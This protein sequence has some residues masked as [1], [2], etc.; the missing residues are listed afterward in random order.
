MRGAARSLSRLLAAVLSMVALGGCAV[1]TRFAGPGYAAGEGVTAPGSGP[2]LVVITEAVQQR[3]IGRRA[4]FLQRVRAVEAALAGRRGLVGYALRTELLGR[5][6]WT[7]SAWL[8]EESL[9]AFVGSAAHLAAMADAEAVTESMAFV[10]IPVE[11][12]DIPLAWDR[13]LAILAREGY[14]YR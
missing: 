10:R 1:C 3:D 14:P 5:R 2:V 6:A 9:R 11:R 13:A 12:A 8:D 7:M 4:A